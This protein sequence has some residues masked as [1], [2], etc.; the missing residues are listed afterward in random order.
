MIS[1]GRDVRSNFL[2]LAVQ[3]TIS[4]IFSLLDK[5]LQRALIS[6]GKCGSP[7][8]KVTLAELS[9]YNLR[10]AFTLN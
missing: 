9:I 4:F 6:L 7:L 3:L 5:L 8:I 1:E 10:H 2:T